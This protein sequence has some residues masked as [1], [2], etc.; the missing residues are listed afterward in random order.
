MT[1]PLQKRYWL[2]CTAEW[3]R[4]GRLLR[5]NRCLSDIGGGGVAG[6][7]GGGVAIVAAAV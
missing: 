4:T 5:K 1:L 3:R 2:P 6:G 7:G